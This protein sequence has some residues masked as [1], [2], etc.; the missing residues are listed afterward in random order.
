MYGILI[1]SPFV[2]HVE[3]LADQLVQSVPGLQLDVHGEE[4]SGEEQYGA[5][6]GYQLRR[7]QLSGDCISR[8]MV[9]LVGSH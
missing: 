6:E 8:R 2:V 1:C 4:E 5:S 3:E 7:R 9:V